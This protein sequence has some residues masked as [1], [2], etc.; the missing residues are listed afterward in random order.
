REDLL[1]TAKGVLHLLDRPRA[2]VFMRRDRFNRFVT[3]LAYLPKDRFNSDLREKVGETIAQAYGGDVEAF[4]PQ[5]GEGQLARVLFVI[6]SIDKSRPD[7][8]SARL[9]QEIASLTRSWEDAYATALMRSDM[10]DQP[11]REQAVHRFG[12]AFTAAYRERYPV[13]EALIDTAQ[14]LQS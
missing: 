8:D 10:F 1:K 6:G 5:L 2:R 7:P 3:A 4:Y 9:D 12:N 13:D 11:S 14:I